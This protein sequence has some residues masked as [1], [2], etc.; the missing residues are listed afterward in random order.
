M[1]PSDELIRAEQTSQVRDAVASLPEKQRATL[2]L[3]YYQKLSYTQ[4]AE[5]MGCSLGTVKTQMFRA[6]QALVKRLPDPDE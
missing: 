6:L 5:S 2:I 1:E 3:V 4:A